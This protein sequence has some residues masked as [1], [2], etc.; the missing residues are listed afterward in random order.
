MSGPRLFAPCLTVLVGVHA[1][2]LAMPAVAEDAACVLDIAKTAKDGSSE[3][4]QE[5]AQATAGATAGKLKDACEGFKAMSLQAT[6]RTTKMRY[7]ASCKP[8]GVQGICRGAFGSVDRHFYN[9]NAKTLAK[10][11]GSCAT[12]GGTWENAK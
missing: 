3:R 5:C 4:W 10:Q 11:Q 9:L 12:S 8:V 2:L 1:A 6:D 7:V